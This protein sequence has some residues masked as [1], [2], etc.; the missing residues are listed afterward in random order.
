MEPIV[1]GSLPNAQN[2]NK[3]ARIYK[4]G[5]ENKNLKPKNISNPVFV[6]LVG[7]PGVGKTSTAK[8]ILGN[9]GLNYDNF[10]NVSL[11][12]LVE[13]IIP[14]RKVTKELYN[15]IKTKK[16]GTKLNNTDYKLLSE[17]YLTTIMSKRNNL[18]LNSTRKRILNKINGIEADKKKAAPLKSTLK[19]LVELRKDGLEYGIFNGFNILYDTTMNSK[20]NIIERDILPLLQKYPQYNYK[21]K[22]ILVTAPVENIKNRIRGRHAKMLSENDPYIRAINVGLTPAFVEENKEGFEMTKAQYKNNPNFEFIEV[23]NPTQ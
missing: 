23:D 11:D 15:K 4:K 1:F 16:A 20:T 18:G 10:Y 21:I 7:A 5:K 3:I 22:V 8:K 2:L 6:I 13:H 17:V 9:Y 12:S 19:S 14:Y